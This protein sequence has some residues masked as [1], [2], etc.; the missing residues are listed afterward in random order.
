MEGT[1]RSHFKYAEPSGSSM[2]KTESVPKYT[3]TFAMFLEEADSIA[4]KNGHLNDIDSSTYGASWMLRRAETL[5]DKV[6][7]YVQKMPKVAHVELVVL[8]KDSLT[9]NAKAHMATYIGDSANWRSTDDFYLKRQW[10]AIP[11]LVS[12]EYNVRHICN[13]E[14]GTPYSIGQYFAN[15]PPL[16]WM[17]RIWQS[18]K[19]QKP[20]H[21]A[22]LTARIFCRAN[23]I[24]AEPALQTPSSLYNL[25]LQTCAM[26]RS[27]L[28]NVQHEHFTNTVSPMEH[29]NDHELHQASIDKRL[30]LLN[31]LV[32]RT[33]MA[34]ET[35]SIPNVT[36]SNVAL[37][38][39]DIRNLQRRL[40]TQVLR[41][42]R[43]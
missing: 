4:V 11:V 22:A 19:Q 34:C 41:L 28:G 13:N 39:D 27:K 35:A 42:L 32:W 9:K 26:T 23:I 20:V 25:M 43:V 17:P 30:S 21:C 18:Q 36:S 10:R 12:Q 16:S 38:N 33:S 40:S 2:E 7:R 3:L 37:E 5:L 1:T 15:M 8:D 24:Q 14:V 29:M 6:V 31:D